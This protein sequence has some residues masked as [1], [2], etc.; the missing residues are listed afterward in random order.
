MDNNFPVPIF[1]ENDLEIYEN[2]I[3][4]PDFNAVQTPNFSSFLK[5]LNGK[6]IKIYIT[7]GNQLTYRQGRL[8]NVFD[9]YIILAQN[10]IKIAIKLSEIK[11]IM[12]T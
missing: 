11:F 10:C 12:A 4:S 6:N 2:F 3:N 5:S 8:L 1:S 9:D 7:V